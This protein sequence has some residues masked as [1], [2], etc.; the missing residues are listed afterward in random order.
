M[1]IEKNMRGLGLELPEVPK[2]VASYVPAVRSGNYVYTSGQVPFVK[3][4][5]MH[6]GKLGGDL[7]IEQGYECARVTAMNC[8]A[9]VKSVIDDLD[10]VK[11]IV[12]LTGFINS[13][14][15]FTDQP[16]VLNGASDLL[17]EIFGERGKHSRLAIGTS[18]LPLGAPLEIDI[19][20]EIG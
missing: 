13:A 11:Q 7:T 14:P 3:G 1:E 4:E 2:P 12:R 19:V 17:V 5:L 16:K 18:E 9:A 10:L 6:R 20:V 15:G 8:L